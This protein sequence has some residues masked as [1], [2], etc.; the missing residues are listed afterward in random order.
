MTYRF[1]IFAFDDRTAVLTR[2][3]RPV[4]LEPQ[5]ARALALLL[6]RAGDLVSREELRAHL[7]GE[8]THVDFDRGLAYCIG[9]LRSALGDSADNP[10]FIQTHP[11]RGFSFIAPVAS[12][13]PERSTFD[14]R[15]S[16][17]DATENAEPRTTNA[18]SRTTNEEPRTLNDPRRS[19]PAALLVATAA[20]FL[21]V[22]GGGWWAVSRRA[23]PERPIVAVAVFDNE[24]GDASRERAVS[25]IADVVVERLTALGPNR[26]GVNGNSKVLRNPRA[27]R[28][29]R[30][31]AR[32]THAAF[33]V[34]GHLQ[35][36][37]GRLSLLMHII[38]LDDGTHVWVQRISRSPDDRLESLDEDVAAQIE[39]AVRRIVL[40]DGVQIS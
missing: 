28:D 15:G 23:A 12:G 29:P 18:E 24:T 30:T 27:D 20:V 40:K 16:S 9:Q 22:A 33:L 19:I 39:K 8:A 21:T 5:P 17:F 25:T 37:D 2:S 14:V 35:T 31:V 10:R 38:R 32:E 4:S 26:I 7:W 36:K 11:R 13:E 6:S 1:G 3:N 34:A